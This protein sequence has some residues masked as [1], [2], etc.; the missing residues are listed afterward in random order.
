M[1][2]ISTEKMYK[3]TTCCSRRKTIFMGIENFI[4]FVIFL[5]HLLKAFEIAILRLS[6]RYGF[7][8]GMLSAKMKIQPQKS[9]HANCCLKLNSTIF[10]AVVNYNQETML[11]KT[12]KM[13]F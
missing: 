2:I 4:T 8:L 7:Q 6:V 12:K 5:W 10:V 1:V 11:V 9:G 3:K 13:S